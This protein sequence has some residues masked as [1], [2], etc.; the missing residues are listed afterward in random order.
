MKINIFDDFSRFMDNGG[1]ILIPFL[2]LA[3][4][5]LILKIVSRWIFFKKCG[6]EGWKALIPVYTDVIFVKISGLNW[7]WVL[8]LYVTILQSIISVI[9]AYSNLSYLQ[10]ISAFASM[11]SF[12]AIFA[13]VNIGYNISKKFNI[14]AGYAALIALLEPIGLL[15]LGLSKNM[16]YDKDSVV[17]PNGFI[18]GNTVESNN[19]RPNDTEFCENCGNKIKK[20]SIYCE[21]C[22][23]KVR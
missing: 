17:S 4:I 21:N 10:V 15:I 5:M 2:F 14:N 12:V 22:G 7:W 8:F 6:E 20:D 1:W 18:K 19:Y 16:N 9:S 11:L 23:N 3:F 13:K